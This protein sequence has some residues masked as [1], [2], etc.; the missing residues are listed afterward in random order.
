[1]GLITFSSRAVSVSGVVTPSGRSSCTNPTAIGIHGQP[2]YAAAVLD[3]G[4]GY[5]R[6]V[7]KLGCITLSLIELFPPS[8]VFSVHLGRRLK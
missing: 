6:P 5:L 3:Q 8:L 7:K 4:D 1:M 2:A